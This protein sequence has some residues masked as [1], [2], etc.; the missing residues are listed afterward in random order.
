MLGDVTDGPNLL[1]GCESGKYF[2]FDR[3]HLTVTGIPEYTV[4]LPLFLVC[5]EA[6]RE[7]F[8]VG[9]LCSTDEGIAVYYNTGFILLCRM[10]VFRTAST[11]VPHCFRI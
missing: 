8:I 7:D 11:V 1:V 5:Q 6:D 2:F 4:T 3:R 9:L 10:D